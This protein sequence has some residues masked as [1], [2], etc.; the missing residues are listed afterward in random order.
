M[1]QVKPAKQAVPI[2]IVGLR[3]IEVVQH[4]CCAPITW[5]PCNPQR[6]SQHTL[7]HPVGFRVAAEKIFPDAATDIRL[8]L[9]V[10]PGT[11]FSGDQI[12]ILR[13]GS[14]RQGP[15]VHFDIGGGRQINDAARLDPIVVFPVGTR[16]D[17]F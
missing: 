17:F 1:R 8:M 15:L 4:I 6:Q 7:V 3:F 11:F 12:G 5:Q 13:G 14:G 16:P 9:F 2:G 10:A